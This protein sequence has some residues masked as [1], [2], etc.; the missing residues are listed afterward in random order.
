MKDCRKLGVLSRCCPTHSLKPTAS[1]D[2]LHASEHPISDADT[3]NDAPLTFRTQK[4][5]Q[6]LGAQYL[7]IKLR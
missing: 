7:I 2:A 3:I 4:G 1:I 5:L 6:I